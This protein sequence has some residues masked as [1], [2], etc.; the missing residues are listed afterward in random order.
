MRVLFSP[1]N[2]GR[3]PH[4]RFEYQPVAEM[5]P[6]PGRMALLMAEGAHSPG[7]IAET[8][9]GRGRNREVPPVWLG[10]SAGKTMKSAPTICS[11]FSLSAP[12]MA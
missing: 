3:K 12:N 2:M 11:H 1:V 10:G 6:A 4:L 9:A 8:A 5:L 7:S